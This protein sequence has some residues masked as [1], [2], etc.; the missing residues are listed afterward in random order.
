MSL[1]KDSS[2]APSEKGKMDGSKAATALRP[3]TPTKSD[4]QLVQ[5]GKRQMATT[6]FN[7][8]IGRATMVPI[9]ASRYT[10]APTTL[11]VFRAITPSLAVVKPAA[12]APAT[13]PSPPSSLKAPN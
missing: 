2:G 12:P 6:P 3:S 9:P 8:P 11:S 1:V 5:A 7:S 10:I 4:S 13:R